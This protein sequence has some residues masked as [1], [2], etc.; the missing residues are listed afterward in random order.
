MPHF[1][2]PMIQNA[3]AVAV[4]V[5]AILAAIVLKECVFL[6][7]LRRIIWEEYGSW[8]MWFSAALVL[9]L[10]SVAYVLIRKLALN[11]TGEKLAHLEKQLRGKASISEELSR[12]I[13]EQ[14]K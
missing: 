10:F 5:Y 7:P 1:G 6:A 14:R 3:L 11:D 9:N 8:L 4:T 13:L 12:Q 2:E